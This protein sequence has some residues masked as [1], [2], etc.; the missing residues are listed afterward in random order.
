MREDTTGSHVNLVNA[1]FSALIALTQNSCHLSDELIAQLL[2]PVLGMLEGTVTQP[3]ANSERNK[4]TQDM[5]A[6]LLQV[7]LVRVGHT[8]SKEV[9]DNIVKLLIMMF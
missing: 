4:D 3:H 2:M 8:V 9:G 7:I 1:S 5:L 6:G